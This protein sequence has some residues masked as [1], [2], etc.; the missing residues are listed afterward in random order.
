MKI[1][2]VLAFFATCIAISSPLLVSAESWQSVHKVSDS[3]SALTFEV[4]STWHLI[5]GRVPDVTG[6]IEITSNGDTSTISGE[7]IASVERFNTENKSRDAE[8]KNVM[9][10]K[11]YPSVTLRINSTGNVCSPDGVKKSG[12]C[13]GTISGSLT[14]RDV[15]RKVEIPYKIT[16]EGDGFKVLGEFE[17]KWEDYGVEDPSI[18]IAKLHDTVKVSFWTKLKTIV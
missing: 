7:V 6:Q 4:D 12:G 16:Q 9:A 13:S 3:N 18:L 11:N 15:T 14:I 1:F 8:L 2:R 17:L 5:H 10:A